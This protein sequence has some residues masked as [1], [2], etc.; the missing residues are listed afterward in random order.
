M[1]DT[2]VRFGDKLKIA[3]FFNDAFFLLGWSIIRFLT[4][5]ASSAEG[6]F[7][8]MFKLF[9][10]F[11]QP[12]FKDLLSQFRGFSFVIGSICLVFFFY[13]YMKNPNMRF[14]SII[15]TLIIGVAVVMLLPTA[16]TKMADYTQQLTSAVANTQNGGMTYQTVNTYMYDLAI[17]NKEK[18]D[19]EETSLLTASP[20]DEN[21]NPKLI[22]NDKNM[23]MLSILERY[24]DSES[25][26]DSETKKLLSKKPIVDSNGAVQLIDKDN[27]LFGMGREEYYRYAIDFLPLAIILVVIAL[28]YIISSLKTVKMIYQIIYT[29]ILTI[30]V[31]FTEPGE[32]GK[33]KKGI[34]NISGNFIQIAFIGYTLFIYIHGMSA[35]KALNLSPLAYIIAILGA[36][37]AV[38]DGSYYLQELTGIESGFKSVG[39][40]LQSMYYG[41]RLL[42]GAGRMVGH[43]LDKVKDLSKDIGRTGIKTAGGVSGFFQGLGQANSEAIKPIDE[44]QKDLQQENTAFSN[45]PSINDELMKNQSLKDKQTNPYD[46]ETDEAPNWRESLSPQED[47]SGNDNM[48]PMTGEP[49]EITSINAN[50]QPSAFNDVPSIDTQKQME[51]LKQHPEQAITDSLKQHKYTST[52][53]VKT[54]LSRVTLPEYQAAT[55]KVSEHMKQSEARERKE[56]QTLTGA[57]K[58]KMGTTA[59]KV[60]T[61][62]A[63][64]MSGE[65]MSKAMDNAMTGRKVGRFVGGSLQKISQTVKVKKSTG[66]GKDT[67]N[68]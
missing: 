8:E 25:T 28:V 17:F 52:E 31:A 47:R 11:E 53:P 34:K 10:L 30:A 67:T 60:I 36:T 14:Q 18:F 66:K 19:N 1:I 26:A 5:I 51:Q 7:M 3:N 15:D 6:I 22:I 4:F 40:T 61:K 49:T 41:G 64:T 54:D 59:D 20:K 63:E 35:L 27:G 58:E 46:K 38:L 39:Q 65:T 13:R 37:F 33:V 2:F 44:Q 12:F 21:A 62:Y 42:G 55:Q 23:G 57:M 45:Q 24:K 9:N 29:A 16:V 50:Q 48:N 68:D 43:T 32:N 56:N